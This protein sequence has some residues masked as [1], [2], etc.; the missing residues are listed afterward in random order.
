[1]R[2]RTTTT[3]TTTTISAAATA[4][5]VISATTATVEPAAPGTA[6]ATAAATT[7]PHA[8]IT[9]LFNAHVDQSLCFGN[10]FVCTRQ[11]KFLLC[12]VWGV[13]PVQLDVRPR[14]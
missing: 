4:A 10:L 1:L 13:V 8:S 5:T 3:T 2:R 12:R 11:D 9:V 7:T 6:A 14:P